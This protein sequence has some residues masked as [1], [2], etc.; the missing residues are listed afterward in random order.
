MINRQF[1]EIDSNDIE[2]L[3]VNQVRESKTIEYKEQ[4]PGNSRGNR[5][6]FLA[7][8]SA[9]ANASGG[10]LLYGIREER[11][12]NGKTTGIPEVAIGLSEINAD[13]VIRRLE[14]II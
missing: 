2:N 8:V 9:F 11:D 5:K 3:I 10:D 4:L 14:G 12:E 13:E 6:E 7:D 1:D